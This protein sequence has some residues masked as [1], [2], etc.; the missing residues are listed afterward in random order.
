MIIFIFGYRIKA[1]LER[2]KGHGMYF[3]SIENEKDKKK[4]IKIKLVH[5][6]K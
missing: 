6:K 2:A 4:K 1:Y 3:D 5:Y